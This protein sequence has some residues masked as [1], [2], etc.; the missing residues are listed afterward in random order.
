MSEFGP[1]P[2]RSNSGSGEGEVVDFDRT[3]DVNKPG[4][5]GAVERW[6]VQVEESMMDTLR[7]VTKQS[8]N[9]YAAKDRLKW[10]QEWPG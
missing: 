6:L 1:G 9:D 3:V 8:N 7:A 2:G 10:C 4:N 5:K